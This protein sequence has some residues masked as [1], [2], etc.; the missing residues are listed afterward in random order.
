MEADGVIKPLLRNAAEVP[1][2]WEEMPICL[3]LSLE[4]APNRKKGSKFL[5]GLVSI[6]R[7]LSNA[8]F[9]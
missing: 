7:L 4:Q 6:Y 3:A 9:G 8:G 1:G 2:L 5:L